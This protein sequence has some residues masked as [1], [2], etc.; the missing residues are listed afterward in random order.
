[1][2]ENTTPQ[3]GD[4]KDTINKK[5]DALLGYMKSK[6]SAPTAKGFGIDLKKFNST[7]MDHVQ[8]RQVKTVGSVRYERG[9][10]G[11]AVRVD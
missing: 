7:A 2:F 6:S 1:M 3:F 11:E 8:P 4:S 10:K 5:R 9:P